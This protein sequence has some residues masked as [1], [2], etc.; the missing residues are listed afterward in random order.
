MRL[1]TAEKGLVSICTGTHVVTQW[2]EQGVTSPV[3]GFIWELPCGC[4]GQGFTLVFRMP[5]VR[6]HGT[7]LPDSVPRTLQ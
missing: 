1:S 7:Q 3:I 6:Y 4:S 5:R 2:Q